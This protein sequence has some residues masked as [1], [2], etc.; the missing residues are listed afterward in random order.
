M[1]SR[2]IE[3][4]VVVE[5]ERNKWNSDSVTTDPMVLVP[6]TGYV[7]RVRTISRAEFQK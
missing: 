6:G 4:D 1:L 5:K 2:R 7:N 3:T